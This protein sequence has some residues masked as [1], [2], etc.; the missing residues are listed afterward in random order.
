MQSK[1]PVVPFLTFKANTHLQNGKWGR[2]SAFKHLLVMFGSSPARQCPLSIFQSLTEQVPFVTKG[3][4]KNWNTEYGLKKFV[5]R[6]TNLSY[7][8]KKR[9]GKN[10]GKKKSFFGIHF[11][12]GILMVDLEVSKVIMCQFLF[13]SNNRKTF[14]L[15]QV[16]G[17]FC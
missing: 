1:I 15:M 4:I 9:E 12:K 13:N 17:F 10:S 8:E 5:Q 7:K 2:K 6:S 11:M 16:R 3:H 14:M